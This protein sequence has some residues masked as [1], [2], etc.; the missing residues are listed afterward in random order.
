MG[1]D[2]HLH[3]VHN[4]ELLKKDIF[5][6]RNSDWFGNLSGRVTEIAYDE[7]PCRYDWD[8]EGHCPDSLKDEYLKERKDEYWSGR[9]TYDERA[10][11]V[12]DFKDWY[13]KYKPYLKAG[14]V[15]R[16]DA[17]VYEKKGIAPSPDD[18]EHYLWESDEP[19][20]GDKVWI[21]FEYSYEPSTWL[22]NYLLDNDIPDDAWLVYCFDC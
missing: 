15:T 18:V 1:V 10:I 22:C 7:F 6:G 19:H 13:V 5:D 9:W 12:K 3:I 11:N 20:I 4:G 14:Y 21:E 16:Y 17:W 8:C 2:I